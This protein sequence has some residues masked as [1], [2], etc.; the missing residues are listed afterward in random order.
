M[1]DEDRAP[2]EE[3]NRKTARLI[4]EDDEKNALKNQIDNQPLSPCP[5]SNQTTTTTSS[6]PP[7]TPGNSNDSRPIGNFPQPVLQKQVGINQ[8]PQ[9]GI[10]QHPP[11]GQQPFRPT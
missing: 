6:T 10:R 7:A 3:D 9:T 8:G 4:K 1:K 2:W 11:I 5:N